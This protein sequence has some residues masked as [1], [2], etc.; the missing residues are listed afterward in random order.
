[1]FKCSKDQMFKINQKN[2]I[3]NE[4]FLLLILNCLEHLNIRI[5]LL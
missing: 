4:K 2:K 5:F 1:M 3:K